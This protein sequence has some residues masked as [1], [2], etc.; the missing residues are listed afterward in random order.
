MI[1]NFINT[2]SKRFLQLCS[3]YRL[4]GYDE[5]VYFTSNSYILVTTSRITDK[6]IS[7]HVFLVPLIFCDPEN[8]S[9]QCRAMQIGKAVYLR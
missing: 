6:I 4:G 7:A 5:R 2:F 9:K 3:P 8:P 1:A